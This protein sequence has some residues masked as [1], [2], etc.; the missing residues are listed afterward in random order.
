M[1]L[2]NIRINASRIALLMVFLLFL[3]NN[4]VKADIFS[5]TGYFPIAVWLQNPSNAAAYR[6]TGINLYVG[7]WNGPTQEQL[8]QLQEAGIPV[9][10]NQNEF[11]LNHLEKYGNV[12]A[13]WMHGDEPDNAQSDGE[14]GYGPCIDPDTIVHGY[15]EIKGKDA[16]RPVYLNLG[17]GVSNIDYIGRGSA[18]HGR[19]DMYPGTSGGATSSRTI[20]IPLTVPM[21]IL[22]EIYGMFRKGSTV[23]GH[24]ASNEKRRGAGSNVPV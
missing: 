15:N 4:G 21:R 9:I 22:L 23:C 14:G 1:K 6:Q 24:G 12:I 8:D 18:C 5:D 20:Y 11:A 3:R 19:A 7:L 16:Q 2:K 10:C 13:G 17:Q